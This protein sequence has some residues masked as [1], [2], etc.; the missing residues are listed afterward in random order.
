MNDNLE[1]EVL[2]PAQGVRLHRIVHMDV[3]HGEGIALMKKT[4]DP[5]GS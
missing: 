3:E 5:K 2:Y 1:V 4:L